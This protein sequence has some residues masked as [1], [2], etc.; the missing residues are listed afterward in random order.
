MADRETAQLVDIDPLGFTH[1][2]AELRDDTD[3]C[4]DVPLCFVGEA[5]RMGAT[6]ADLNVTFDQAIDIED[7]PRA[8]DPAQVSCPDC[9]EWIHA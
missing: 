1:L 8:D 4:L 6:A 9:K 5:R 7:Y 3:D 2:R